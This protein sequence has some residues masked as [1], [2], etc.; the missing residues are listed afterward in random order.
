MATLVLLPGMDGTG[1][2][3]A[4]FV[5]AIGPEANTVIVSYP[6]DLA[7]D[8]GQLEVFARDRLPTDEPFVL[9]AESFS[10]PIAVSIAASAPSGLR[11]LVLCCTFVTSPRPMLKFL[12]LVTRVIPIGLVPIKL[13]GFILLGRFSTSAARRALAEVLAQVSPKALRTRLAALFDVNV[14]GL[15][16]QVRVP[17]LYLCATED[18]VVPRAASRHISELLPEAK[19]IEIGAPHFLLQ[20]AP[21]EAAHHVTQFIRNV[22]LGHR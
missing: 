20:S 19:V 17:V 2:L 1:R 22:A 8:Y 16:A 9:L 21:A 14:A 15:L 18:R 4:D 13:L 7:L 6:P 12:K 5:D 11:G 3:F 10:G